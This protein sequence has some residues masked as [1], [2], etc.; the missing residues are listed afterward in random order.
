MGAKILFVDDEL[1]MCFMV[2]NL[3]RHHGYDVV[4]AEN[5]DVAL[6]QA[7]AYPLSLIILDANLAGEDGFKLMTFLKQNHPD[8]PIIIYTGMSHD[9]DT[10]QRALAMG[11]RQYL[12]KGAPVD[13]LISAVKA[14]VPAEP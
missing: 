3:L 13:E 10:V 7:D 5:A 8:V 1:E 14:A 2:S 6:G 4:T 12:R 9:E 11:A